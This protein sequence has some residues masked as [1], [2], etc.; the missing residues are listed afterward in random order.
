M[1]DLVYKFP[2]ISRRKTWALIKKSFQSK[3][4]VYFTLIWAKISA[5]SGKR[6]IIWEMFDIVTRL[7]AGIAVMS[8]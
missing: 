8:L 1:I 5:L 6:H 2:M 7:I 3:N 4:S